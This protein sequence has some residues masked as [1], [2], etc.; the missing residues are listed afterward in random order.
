M[1]EKGVKE[2]GEER[3]GEG[4]KKGEGRSDKGRRSHP[5]FCC[6]VAPLNV[7]DYDEDSHA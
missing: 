3:E 4:W 7:V 6:V 1:E 2:G 5:N